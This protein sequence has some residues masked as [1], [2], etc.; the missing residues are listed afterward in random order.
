MFEKL[1]TYHALLEKWQ[2]AINLVS[3]KSL[4]E[5]WHRHFIDSA[6]MC[7][8]IPENTKIY[9]DLGCGGGF[10]GL[11]LA[12]MRPNLE[13]HLVESDER[14]GQFMRSVVRET[15]TSNVTIHTKRVEAVMGDITPD[16]V[17]ARALAALDK[18]FDLCWPWAEQNAALTFCF[19]KGERAEE[20]IERA[21]KTYDFDVHH[22]SSI[23]D[24]HAQILGITNLKKRS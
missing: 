4:P 10:P 5:S 1:E 13:V 6:Q 9:A 12:I 19:M 8:H 11:V 21:R 23:T 18:L 2:K 22:H 7:A 14:K 15:Q 17:T 20:E 24:A 3:S 16:F